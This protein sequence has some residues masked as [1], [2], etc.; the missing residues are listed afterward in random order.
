MRGTVARKVYI[1]L[2]VVL[3][4]LASFPLTPGAL[5][6][7]QLKGIVI[8]LLYCVSHQLLCQKQLEALYLRWKW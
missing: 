7:L 3:T 2:I 4:H 1:S 6:L 5:L 8:G